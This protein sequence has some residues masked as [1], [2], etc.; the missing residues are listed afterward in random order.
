M[1]KLWLHAPRIELAKLAKIDFF[2]IRPGSLEG[3]PFIC[4]GTKSRT[5]GD[6]L[7]LTT[8]PAKIR[9]KYP[10]MEI[11]AYPRGFNPVVFCGNPHVRSVRYLP[12]KVFGDDINWGEGHLIQ[13][14]ER[15]F[16][17]PIAEPPRPELHLLEGEI[18][19]AERLTRG[20]ARPIC[21]IH[22][23]G[24]TVKSV[25]T[26]HFWGA[27]VQRWSHAYRFWQL[28]IT[29]H[30]HVP[31]CEKY[32]LLPHGY[33]HARKAF[34]AMSRAKLFIG[35]NSGPMHIARAFDVPSVI[36]TNEGD[37]DTIFR[38]RKQAAWFLYNNWRHSFLYEEN[39][40][41]DVAPL[42]EDQLLARLDAYLEEHHP[43]A[44]PGP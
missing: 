4:L 12:R 38:T 33:H 15:F 28:G 6:A 10:S 23:W 39:L 34:A 41:I 13:L 7:M 30:E 22:P 2:P 40:H 21:V 24:G 37:I 26:R 36:L 42:S 14:K 9:A 43:S 31:G 18:S 44:R 25:A 3:E 19:W 20:A 27:L 32:L 35:I 8:L 5:I 11:Y 17:L 16:E 1:R 29:G